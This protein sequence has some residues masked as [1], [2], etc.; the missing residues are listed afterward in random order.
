MHP[1][2]DGVKFYSVNDMS[3]GWALKK[4]EPILSAFDDSVQ[5]TDI[6]Q[7][8]ELYNIQELMGSGVALQAWSEEQHECYKSVAVSFHKVIACFFAKIDDSNFVITNEKV[9][10]QYL[11]DFW[12]L[13]VRY[14]LYQRISPQCFHTYLCLP[15]TV[16]DKVLKHK[17]IVSQYGNEL[18]DVMRSSQQTVR[19]LATKF[20]EKSSTKY[21]IPAELKPEEFEG[22]FSKYIQSNQVNANV[23]QLIIY[24]QSTK[25]CPISDKLRLQAKRK[26]KEFWED[27]K[28]AKSSTEY[29]VSVRFKPQN[30]IK[31]ESISGTVYELT[32]DVKWFEDNLDY[33]TILNNFRYIFEM[34]DSSF[35]STLVST[36]SQMSALEKAFAVEGKLFYPRGFQFKFRAIQSR[37]QMSL[38]HHLLNEHHIDLESV[39]KWFFEE[40]LPVE[41]NVNGFSMIASSQSA[42]YAERCRSLACEMDSVLKQ[43]RM[44]VRDGEIDRE[45]FEMSEEHMVIDTLPSLLTNKYAYANSKEIQDEMFALFSDQSVLSYIERTG[46]RYSTL[47][48]LLQT[49]QVNIDEFKEYQVASINWLEKRGC[50]KISAEGCVELVYP[51]VVILNDLYDN[52][53]I[54]L[55]YRENWK[56]VIDQMISCGDLRIGNTLFSEPER[57]YLNYELNKSEFS[58]GLDLRNKYAHGT[59]PLG[60]KE[61]KEDYMELLKLMVLIVTKI[62]N[63]FCLQ[64]ELKKAFQ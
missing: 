53:V 15:E 6:N 28:T 41:Y 63:E 61:Q 5:Y 25:E 29:G 8:I 17:E 37:A 31:L 64:E 7:V 54:C 9:A 14:K 22:I 21:Y 24:S 36:K 2:Y 62:N 44:Y 46:S 11:D 39:Y 56:T 4:A 43:F 45:L 23:L 38:Y 20:L 47:V 26:F 34:L 49:E 10:I 59:Y 40:Y 32:Y 52:D 12:T 35:R 1:K 13:F 27:T 33:P 58:D 42:S 57:D 50:I 18:A 16:I 55:H 48:E 19:I 3:V 60:E 51:N 30:E